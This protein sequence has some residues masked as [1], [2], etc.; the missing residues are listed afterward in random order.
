MEHERLDYDLLSDRFSAAYG[1]DLSDTYAAYEYDQARD[2]VDSLYTEAQETGDISDWEA[3]WDF[4][5]DEMGL[6][7][8][9]F[10]AFF[11]YEEAA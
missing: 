10:D 2:F 3:L 6:D 9:D 11:G 5:H 1:V 4:L 7:Y 8:D